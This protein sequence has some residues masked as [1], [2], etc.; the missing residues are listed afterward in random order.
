V[1]AWLDATLVRYRAPTITATPSR[2]ISPKLQITATKAKP[3]FFELES[4]R[5]RGGKPLSCPQ[6]APEKPRRRLIGPL[7]TSIK[8][9]AMAI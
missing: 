9:L 5:N 6:I 2:L 1:D 8:P 7:V 4:D 3:E